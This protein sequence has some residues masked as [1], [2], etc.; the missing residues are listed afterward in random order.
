MTEAL[1]SSALL[2]LD[3]KMSWW[4]RSSAHSIILRLA[5][6]KEA[7]KMRCQFFFSF[8]CMANSIGV[9]KVRLEEVKRDILHSGLYEINRLQNVSGVTD[10]HT[11]EWVGV[12]ESNAP[13][14]SII[15]ALVRNFFHRMLAIKRNWLFSNRTRTCSSHT[16]A[17]H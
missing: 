5:A 4:I 2:F 1:S 6:F 8:L 11:E 12:E 16:G 7:V 14:L 3:L 13:A 10:K 9:Q 15:N 17:L